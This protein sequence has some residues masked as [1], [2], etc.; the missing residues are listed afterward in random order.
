MSFGRNAAVRSAIHIYIAEGILKNEAQDHKSFFGSP[1]KAGFCTVLAFLCLGSCLGQ[2]QNAAPQAPPQPA[3]DMVAALYGLVS[4]TGGK[5][6]DWD[7]VRAYFLKEAVIVLRTSRTATTVF[8]LDGFIKDFVDFYERPFTRGETKVL[9]K[10]SGF[11]EKVVRMKTWE[12]GDMA[13]VLV[14]YEASITGFP[15]PPQQG[16]DS[17]LLVRRDGRWWIAAAT[18]ELVTPARPIPPELRIDVQKRIGPPAPDL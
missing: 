7:K 4:S 17:W 13:H 15:M 16:V 11:T 9:P 10:D 5:L 12:Y 8:S 2:T 1:G 14:L 6:P 3:G 18:N